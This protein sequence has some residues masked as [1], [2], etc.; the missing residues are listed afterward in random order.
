[1]SDWPWPAP[2][3]DGAAAHLVPGLALPAVV[4]PSTK[5]EPVAL[6]TRPGRTLLAVYPWTGRPG[7]DNPPGWDDIPGAHG[8]TPELEGFRDLHPRFRAVGVTVYGV[9][10]Q[11]AEWQTELAT[12]L[13]LPFPLL[14]DAAGELRAT[15]SL[16]AFTVHGVTYLRRLTLLLDAGRII[17]C[18]Y[19]VHPPDMHAAE[20]LTW[21]EAGPGSL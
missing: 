5:G 21:L 7:M 15:L 16:P 6:A 11:S 4:L 3:D 19:P 8:S 1:M 17:R 2:P 13:A 9:S 14:S 10:G 18:L 20:V 12:R